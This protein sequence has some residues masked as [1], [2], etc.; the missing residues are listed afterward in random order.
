MT[1]AA[2]A[3]IFSRALEQ[4]G[5]VE[6]A[7]RAADWAARKPGRRS[8]LT[9]EQRADLRRQ[10]AAGASLKELGVAFG[11]AAS[12]ASILARDIK[13]TAP[14]RGADQSTPLSEALS[15]HLGQHL[16]LAGRWHRYHP[17]GRRP[18]PQL[19]GHRAIVLALRAGGASYQEIAGVLGQQ[20]WVAIRKYHTAKDDAEARDL[21]Q[22]ALAAVQADLVEI[23]A[24]AQAPEHR[25]A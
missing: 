19:L 21:A 10:R 4:T 14:A 8:R 20:T 13:P 11:I 23:A 15:R 12:Y 24:P 7:L 6:E 5:S 3:E 25:A 16:G 18:R 2:K 1:Y 9:P 17:R 22:A